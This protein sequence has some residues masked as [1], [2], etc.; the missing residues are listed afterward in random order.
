MS[1]PQNFT[2]VRV[3]LAL[4]STISGSRFLGCSMDP[5]FCLICCFCSCAGSGWP[6]RTCVGL[7]TVCACVAAHQIHLSAQ[8]SWRAVLLS[9]WP[10][11]CFLVRIWSQ[12]LVLTSRGA[13]TTPV[14]STRAVHWS[15]FPPGSRDTRGS[16][17]LVRGG[18]LS[19]CGSESCGPYLPE[20]ACTRPAPWSS[21]KLHYCL[22][23]S[24]VLWQGT[25]LVRS[26]RCLW[27]WRPCGL[28]RVLAGV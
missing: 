22:A 9:L 6:T 21:A 15:C 10:L 23:S 24:V 7:A 19:P 3:G 25:R 27:D 5:L 11:P 12:F 16:Q 13:P 17:P 1:S 2:L 28:I 18:R 26:W 4:F 14:L 8:L 20:T